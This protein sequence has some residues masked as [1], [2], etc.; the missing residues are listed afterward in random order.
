MKK[1]RA[2]LTRTLLKR[3]ILKLE[4]LDTNPALGDVVELVS[5][6]STERFT[7]IGKGKYLREKRRKTPKLII[8]GMNNVK[9]FL[10]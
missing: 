7:Y 8:S 6:T 4:K 10:L 3:R 2:C 5:S 1:L 9:D